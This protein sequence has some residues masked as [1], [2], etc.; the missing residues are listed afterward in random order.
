MAVTPKTAAASKKTSTTDTAGRRV[1]KKGEPTFANYVEKAI[2]TRIQEYADWLERETGF[3]VDARS[4]YLGSA[5]R[6]T[7]QKSEEN[8]TRISSRAQEI[9]DQAA[10]R[11]QAKID[12]AEAKAQREVERAEKAEA[13]KVAAAAKAEEVAAAKAAKAAE[14]KPEKVVAAKKAPATKKAP[15]AKAAPAKPA[16]PARRRPAKAAAETNG[17]F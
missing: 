5:L 14:P 1:A 2:P 8:Q 17:D 6:G 11:E 16:A 13:R 9:L 10:A 7:F 4:V 15:A 12:R 3:A